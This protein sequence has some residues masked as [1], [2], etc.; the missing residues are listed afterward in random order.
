MSSTIQAPKNEAN[1]QLC[2]SDDTIYFCGELIRLGMEICSKWK[3]YDYNGSYEK[4]WV[5]LRL[6]TKRATKSIYIDCLAHSYI[7]I[8]AYHYYTRNLGKNVKQLIFVISELTKDFMTSRA[9]CMDPPEQLEQVIFVC[10][11]L[12]NKFTYILYKSN[13]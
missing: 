10:S 2:Q 1:K 6:T 11:L 13:A 7:A 12:I 4:Q 3:I 8:D 9:D 5:K